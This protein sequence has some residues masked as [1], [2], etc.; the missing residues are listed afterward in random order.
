MDALSLKSIVRK[1][2]VGEC[3]YCFSRLKYISSICTVGEL[4]QNGMS[5]NYK[6]SD[7][8]GVWCD[9][10]GYK[11]SATEIGLKLIPIDRISEFD[12]NWDKKYLE[13]NTLVYGEKGKNPFNKDKE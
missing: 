6:S 8:H 4:E 5:A 9:R 13:D 12:I 2:N 10:C 7:K 11:S 1:L 3:P